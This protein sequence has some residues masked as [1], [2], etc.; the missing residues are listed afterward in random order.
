M[1]TPKA[2]NLF[3]LKICEYYAIWHGLPMP[4]CKKC[5]AYCEKIFDELLNTEFAWVRQPVASGR[6]PIPPAFPKQFFNIN[7][8]E[9]ANG[10][11][12]EQNFREK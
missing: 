9:G 6:S 8:W 5:C 3:D 12:K 7:E 4:D 1:K 10:K 11:W 2:I